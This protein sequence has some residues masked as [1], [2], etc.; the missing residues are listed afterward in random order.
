MQDIKD[1]YAD[2]KTKI[3]QHT[4][5]PAF[6]YTGIG[7][8]A[9]M[10]NVNGGLD[11]ANYHQYPP[12]IQQIKKTIP[13][14]H[15]YIV[16]IDP[17]QEQPPYMLHDILSDF[18]N[19]MET[20]N[21][22]N[23]NICKDAPILYSDKAKKIHIY[24]LPKYVTTAPYQDPMSPV[25]YA[26]NR[27][28][29]TDDLRELNLFATT[30]PNVTTFYHD[31]TGRRNDILAEY[32]DETMYPSDLDHIVYG[33]STR[34]D[35]GCYFDLSAPNA[36]MPFRL[37]K[38]KEKNRVTFFNIFKYI[39]SEKMHMQKTDIYSSADD[40]YLIELQRESVLLQ[41]KNDFKNNIFTTMRVLL[42]LIRGEENKDVMNIYIFAFVPYNKRAHLEE[43]YKNE[44]YREIFDYLM[45]FFSKKMDIVVK[46]KEYDFTGRELIGFI[47]NEYEK[48]L[49]KWI[50]TLNYFIPT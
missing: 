28:D 2:I 33:L 11:A 36:F 29:I 18:S 40:G 26:A 43:K 6:I 15:L 27:I 47:I 8:A 41:I 31:F 12:L 32:F 35:H 23:K 24:T 42:K 30:E 48:N 37:I 13:A 5:E 44:C 4:D 38:E 1:I 45:D 39:R 16:L 19:E 7:T 46:L 17:L 3:K 9:G 21:A 49:Y 10:R 50:D 22:I 20:C 25:T 14:L 34:E